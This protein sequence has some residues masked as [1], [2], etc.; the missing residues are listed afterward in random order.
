[1]INGGDYVWVLEQGM[2]NEGGDIESVYSTRD[3]AL[4]GVKVLQKTPWRVTQDTS[5]KCFWVDQRDWMSIRKVEV[6]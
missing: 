6:V 2:W 5:D 3:R 4:E 1:M